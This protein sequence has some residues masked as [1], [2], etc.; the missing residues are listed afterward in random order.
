MLHGDA[1][2]RQR[3]QRLDPQRAVTVLQ[4]DGLFVQQQPSRPLGP[5]LHQLLLVVLLSLWIEKE[6]AQQHFRQLEQGGVD[7]VRLSRRT[8]RLGAFGHL[9]L[10]YG[11]GA[12]RLSFR[13]RR[14]FCS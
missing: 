2:P 12:G 3:P 14:Q 1:E 4:L 11:A 10:P 13:Q 7:L 8:R 5:V 9:W 6:I